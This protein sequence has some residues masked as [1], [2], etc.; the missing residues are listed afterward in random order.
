MPPQTLFLSYNNCMTKK[1]WGDFIFSSCN[2]DCKNTPGSQNQGKT[3]PVV[4]TVFASHNSWHVNMALSRYHGEETDRAKP[5]YA[6]NMLHHKFYFLGNTFFDW[7]CFLS[8]LILFYI[9]THIFLFPDSYFLNP[10][11]PVR[12]WSPS[13]PRAARQWRE[14]CPSPSGPGDFLGWRFSPNLRIHSTVRGL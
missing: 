12:T 1:H 7:G 10:T 11:F 13:N 2:G 3:T 9:L 8:W 14:G 5:A 6:H 4:R